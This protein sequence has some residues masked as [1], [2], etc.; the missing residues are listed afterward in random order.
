[1]SKFRQH[2]PFV[3]TI[4]KNKNKNYDIYANQMKGS[5]AFPCRKDF[6]LYRAKKNQPTENHSSMMIMTDP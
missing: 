3:S 6:V 5:K 2:T 1:M 4:K